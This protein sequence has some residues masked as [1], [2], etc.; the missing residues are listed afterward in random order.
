MKSKEDQ[1]IFPNLVFFKQIQG[2]FP[3][4]EYFFE[5][6]GPFHFQGG[7]RTLKFVWLDMQMFN[8]TLM[9]L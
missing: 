7:V 4:R 2:G 5:I 1:A 6:P 3:N 9:K 8:K